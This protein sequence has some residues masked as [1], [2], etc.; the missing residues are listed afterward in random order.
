VTNSNRHLEPAPQ[1]PDQVFE[2]GARLRVDRR[3]RLIHQ[4]DMRLGCAL[5][6][7]WRGVDFL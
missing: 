2:I 6:A 4:Q 5:A 3:E 7:K 1:G